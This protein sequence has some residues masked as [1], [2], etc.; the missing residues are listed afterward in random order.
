LASPGWL[1]KPAGHVRGMRSE[2]LVKS[3][4]SCGGRPLIAAQRRAFTPVQA[5]LEKQL[6]A[7]TEL[8]RIRAAWRVENVRAAMQF[9]T[10]IRANDLAEKLPNHAGE[11]RPFDVGPEGSVRAAGPAV[12]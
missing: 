10:S 5:S 7:E 2:L 8:G 11:V 1:K 4:Y 9:L 3:P 12:G 6:E